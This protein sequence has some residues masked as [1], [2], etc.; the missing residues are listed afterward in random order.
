[1]VTL[2]AS[3]AKEQF[4]KIL[5]KTH[6]FGSSFTITHNGKPYAVL[7]STDEYEGLME[8]IDILKDKNLTQELLAA[9]KEADENKTVSFEEVAG[10]KQVS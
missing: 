6:D 1:M 3:A 5:R 2:T 10:R 4:L 7:L 9:I 8:T